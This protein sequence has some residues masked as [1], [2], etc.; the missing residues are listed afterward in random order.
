MNNGRIKF[1]CQLVADTLLVISLQGVNH[2][3]NLLSSFDSNLRFT[4]KFLKNEVPYICDFELSPGRISI[5][6]KDTNTGLYVNY[7]NVIAWWYHTKWINS[8][9]IHASKICTSN[10]S[11]SELKLIEK[12]ASW[13]DFPKH[14]VNNITVFV[15]LFRSIKIKNNLLLQRNKRNLF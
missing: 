6:S 7:T 10:K 11:S 13:N 4:I 9:V 15:K 14:I 1:Y 5:Y 8:L 3:H 12:Y 2:K